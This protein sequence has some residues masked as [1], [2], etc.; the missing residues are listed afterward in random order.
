MVSIKKKQLGFTLI[1]LLVV[2]AIISI[3]SVIIFVA[4]DPVKR[5]K[6]A[7]ND[8]RVHGVSSILGALDLYRVD[9]QGHLPAGIDSSLK[10]LGTSSTNC[11]VACGTSSSSSSSSSGT[12]T[13]DE[14]S[15]FDEGS[16]SDTQYD[17]GN[18]WIELDSTGQSNGSGEYI[19]GVKDIGGV[20]SWESI[21]WTPASPFGKELPNS[22]GV[23][24]AYNGGNADM[25]NNVLLMHLNDTT[26]SISDTSGSGNSGSYNGSLFSQ[27]G[28]LKTALGFDGSDD[29]VSVD[30]SSSL[31]PTSALS[32]EAWVK[33]NINPGDGDNW[34]NIINKNN[35]NQY[36][37]QHSQY[38]TAFEFAI[39]TANGRRYISSNT[40]PQQGAWYHL[41]ATYDGSRIRLY[42]NGVL[43]SDVGHSGAIDTSNYRLVLG[44]RGWNDRY[45]NG[46]LDEVVVYGRALGDDEVLA[47]YKRGSLNIRHQVR[48]CDNSSCNGVDYIGP[49]G[50][51][52]SYY[53]EIDNLSLELPQ[54]DLTSVS[55]NQY[56][57]YRSVFSSFDSSLTPELVSMS[58]DYS[59]A[60]GSGEMTESSCLDF[61][62]E[63]TPYLKTIP[64]DPKTGS[65][66][67]T[68]YAVKKNSDDLVTVVSCD[69]E[70]DESIAVNH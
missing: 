31:N 15:E 22:G 38:N 68:R 16:Y 34:A 35:D 65:S 57:Q 30:N 55:D 48:S 1:E 44:S 52:S 18:S 10:M 32:L 43:E 4:L 36:Q 42:V 61:S 28:R 62:T 2:I 7:R 37:L 12:L 8:T 5:F 49:D 46:D 69:A 63:L 45:F 23:E 53:S 3:L 26:T 9:H 64:I 20:G 59:N 40:Q 11:D 33:W 67:V 56:F 47:H 50:T 51:T 13:D 58:L 60:S 19:S 14:E 24:G 39:R 27:T 70:L 54:F 21:Y 41:V 17:S 66:E 6:E 25:S 29:Q